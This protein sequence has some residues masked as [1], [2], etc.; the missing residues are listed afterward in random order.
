MENIISIKYLFTTDFYF[1]NLLWYNSHVN[2]KKKIITEG[3]RDRWRIQNL[4]LK[5]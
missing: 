5:E 1:L 2:F 4:Q 3:E